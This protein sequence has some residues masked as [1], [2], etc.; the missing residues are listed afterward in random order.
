MSRRRNEGHWKDV[1]EWRVGGKGGGREE[2][3]S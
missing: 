1:R 2:R 3:E